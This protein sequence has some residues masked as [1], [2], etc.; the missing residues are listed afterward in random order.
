M[1]L[2][3]RERVMLKVAREKPTPTLGEGDLVIAISPTRGAQL[4]SV[5][6]DPYFTKRNVLVRRGGPRNNLEGSFDVLTD[7]RPFLSVDVTCRLLRE[8]E[9][10]LRKARA[11]RD[12]A[13]REIAELREQLARSCATP[14]VPR[15][16]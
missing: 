15:R 6:R 5:L 2:G 11:Q 14:I 9:E 16:I 4:A 13:V 7:A 12:A 1:Q 10:D 8:L 3:F